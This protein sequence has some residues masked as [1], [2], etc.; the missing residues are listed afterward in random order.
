DACPAHS[1]AWAVRMPCC[2]SVRRGPVDA[3]RERVQPGTERGIERGGPGDTTEHVITEGG[4]VAPAELRAPAVDSAVVQQRPQRVAV[5]AGQ[6]RMD[7]D[8]GAE[9]VLTGGGPHR[10]RLA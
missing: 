1:E 6:R 2:A 3:G 10:P 9:R 7:V 5:A 8:D 4:R